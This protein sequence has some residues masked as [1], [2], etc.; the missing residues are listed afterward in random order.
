MKDPGFTESEFR[1]DRVVARRCLF[2]RQDLSMLSGSREESGRVKFAAS[3]RLDIQLDCSRQDLSRFDRLCVSARNCSSGPLLAALTLVFSSKQ[4]GCSSTPVSFSGGREILS[5]SAWVELLFPSESFG[6]YGSPRGWRD[7]RAMTLSFFRDKADKDRGEVGVF[8]ESVF[9]ERR[10]PVEGPR[11]TERGLIRVLHQDHPFALCSLEPLSLRP[12]AM[13]VPA[14]HP[15]PREGADDI[16]AGRIM[17]QN[18]SEAI[19]WRADPL[20]LQEWTHFLNRHHFLRGVAQRLEE[21]GE[22]RYARFLARTLRSW[23]VS[24]PVPVGSNGGAGPSWETL[25][26]AWRL[27]EWLWLLESLR[28]TRLFDGNIRQLVLRSVW[29]HARSLM[30]HKGHPTNWIIVESAALALAGMAFP[31]FVEACGWRA[32]GVRRLDFEFQRQFF[33]DGAHYEISPL[34]HAISLGACLDVFIAAATRG[35][36]LPGSFGAS[37]ERCS[38]YLAALCRPNFTWPSINDSGSS[39][40]TYTELMTRAGEIFKRPDLMWIGSKG[41]R[42]TPPAETF[43]LFPDAGIVTMRSGYDPQARFLTFRAGPPGAAHIHGDALSLDVTA[44]GSPILVDPGITTYGPGPLTDHYRSATAHNTILIDGKGPAL[45]RMSFEERVEPAG[46]RLT[47]SR[48]GL[49]EA[50]TGTCAGFVDQSGSRCIAYRT[51]LFVAREYWVVLD[52]VTGKGTH[53]IAVC[54]QFF[55]GLVRMD[56]KKE[57][58]SR[59]SISRE[60]NEK[61]RFVIV[62]LPGAERPLIET[63]TGREEPPGGWISLDG[64]DCPATHVRFGFKTSLP[65]SFLWLLF[66]CGEGSTSSLTASRRD[67]TEGIVCVDVNSPGGNRDMLTFLPLEASAEKISGAED[68]ISGPWRA[69][70]SRNG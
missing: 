14:P 17:G 31:Q 22:E 49:I 20:G 16:L 48:K 36:S 55:P 45:S 58:F 47:G 6:S 21:T 15:Y 69:R 35:I 32:E 3:G 18:L 61:A 56:E 41:R 13:A 24:N 40:G 26:A 7:I 1:T 34:Y 10:L 50:A 66:P 70:L 28:L 2:T 30:D 60:N 8:L 63:S 64:S 29:E 25:T 23:M 19:D 59:R 44:L 54:W 51:V 42:G 62:P 12:S 53:E 5:P 39:A 11:L 68:L 46:T 37:L 67:E 52:H 43:R 38:E 65:A 4:P 57:S 9:G 33:T 27:R